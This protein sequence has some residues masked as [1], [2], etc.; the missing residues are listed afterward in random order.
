MPGFNPKGS[1]VHYI[2]RRGAGPI[3]QVDA[4]P[5]S[6]HYR[7]AVIG[8][9]WW[10]SGKKWHYRNTKPGLRLLN[11]S[12]TITQWQVE[13]YISQAVT[14]IENKSEFQNATVFSKG[15]C[16]NAMVLYTLEL[17]LFSP[18][19]LKIMC[20]STESVPLGRPRVTAADESLVFHVT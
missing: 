20:S 19:I 13:F 16:Q 15:P 6:A 7:D 18:L 14:S 8:V 2:H 5:T 11:K 4:S 3:N 10:I 12:I 17:K 1:S 9:C